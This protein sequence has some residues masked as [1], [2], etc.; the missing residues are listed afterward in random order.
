MPTI[1]KLSCVRQPANCVCAAG[2]TWEDTQPPP[3]KPEEWQPPKAD[4]CLE[5]YR[6]AYCKHADGF[7]VPGLMAL[8]AALCCAQVQTCLALSFSIASS[9]LITSHDS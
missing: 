7:F 9:T 6:K 3:A 1:H 8:L 2:Q 5:L 4:T